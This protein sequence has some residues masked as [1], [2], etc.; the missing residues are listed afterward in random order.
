M[1]GDDHVTCLELTVRV[2]R[3]EIK[4]DACVYA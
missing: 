3:C 2:I 4:I 1:S